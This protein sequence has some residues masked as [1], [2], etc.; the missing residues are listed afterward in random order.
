ME[1]DKKYCT[2]NSD[3]FASILLRLFLR[4]LIHLVTSGAVAVQD[5]VHGPKFADIRSGYEAIP[6]Y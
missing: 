4:L 6:S 5:G 3:G 2:P 1:A